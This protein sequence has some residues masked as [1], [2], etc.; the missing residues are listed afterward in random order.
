MLKLPKTIRYTIL[1]MTLGLLSCN[2]KETIFLEDD[3]ST[4]VDTVIN[5]LRYRLGA[6]GT[7][8]ITG[9]NSWV[10]TSHTNTNCFQKDT[11]RC[12]RIDINYSQSS[13]K[14]GRVSSFNF[15]FTLL[16]IDES[17]PPPYVIIFQDWVRIHDDDID[18]NRPIST[19]KLEFDN[20]IKL[21]HYDNAWQWSSPPIQGNPASLPEDRLNGEYSIETG[22]TYAV[23]FVIF[24]DSRASLIVNDIVVSDA[25]YQTKHPSNSHAIQW[26]L[27]W[28]KGYNT[29]LDPL[30]RIVISIDEFKIP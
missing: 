23:E 8:D 6:N 26:G 12:S 25:I 1:F 19:I 29:E 9:S 20:G 18:G 24:D 2:D 22:V 3:S 7:I 28:A 16:S 13:Y 14:P 11:T 5:G 17:A 27:Y 30:K 4:L 15:E 10:F 21:R